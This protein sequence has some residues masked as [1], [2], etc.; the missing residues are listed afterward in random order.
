MTRERIDEIEAEF[1]KYGSCKFNGPNE[2]AEFCRLAR[3]AE[4]K[5]A[6]IAR[7][8]DALEKVRLKVAGRQTPAFD[9]VCSIIDAALAPTQPRAGGE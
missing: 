2:V 1:A 3:I 7:L 8:R 6:E 5:D 9:D 4:S